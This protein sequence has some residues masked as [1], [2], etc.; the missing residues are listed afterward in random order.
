MIKLTIKLDDIIQYSVNLT[1]II[2]RFGKKKNKERR[3]G[4]VVGGR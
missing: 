1:V 4:S 2:Y 3:V